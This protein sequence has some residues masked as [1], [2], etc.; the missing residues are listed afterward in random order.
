MF[1][2][3]RSEEGRICGEGDLRIECIEGMG[4]EGQSWMVDS[5]NSRLVL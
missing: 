3:L 1:I 4:C 2:D 5:V